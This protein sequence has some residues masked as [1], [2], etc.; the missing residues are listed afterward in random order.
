LE[1]SAH[2]GLCSVKRGNSPGCDEKLIRHKDEVS[3]V[4]LRIFTQPT[5][6]STKK[7]TEHPKFVARKHPSESGTSGCGLNAVSHA[8]YYISRR[9]RCERLISVSSRA[10]LPHKIE[11]GT[12]VCRERRVGLQARRQVRLE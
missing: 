12:I 9:N 11:C 3:I 1:S 8:K 10:V 7:K 4:F 6:G 2:L 5:N